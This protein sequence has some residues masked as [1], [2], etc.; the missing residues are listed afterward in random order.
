MHPVLGSPG[1]LFLY[2]LA[3]IPVALLLA[4]L[5]HA[6]PLSWQELALV[7]PP[8]CAVYAFVCL[9]PWY[10]CRVMPIEQSALTKL[11]L[12][13]SVAAVVAALGWIVIAKGL[14]LL[15]SRWYPDLDTRF[16]RQLP[17]LFG[18]GILLY[19]LSVALHYHVLSFQTAQEAEL[20]IQEARLFAREAE[21]KALRAQ[22]NPHFLFNSLNSISA[23]TMVDAARARDMCIRLADFLRSTLKAGEKETISFAE[24]LS[25]ANTYLGVEQIRFGS[26][27]RVEQNVAPACSECR[28]P[29][30]VLQPLVENAIKH[31]VA[32][33]LEGGTIHFEAACSEG[34][35]WLRLE[36]DFD[37]DAPA[38]QRTGLGLANV[39]G[40]LRARYED[41]ARLD[42]EIAGN[43]FRV[44][45]TLPCEGHAHA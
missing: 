31:G 28:V 18:I 5:M 12:N 45:L 26:R 10:L 25:L 38:P 29:P 19:L 17:L 44:K 14:A 3:W 27:L 42:T 35:L 43:C 20:R 39:R 32:G 23:L 30:L 1:R 40:R 16:S 22:I 9:S 36:N 34:W 6:V 21:L 7:L 33:M 2:L 15:L 24:E 37:P 4:F 41:R 13:H 8:L 11:L